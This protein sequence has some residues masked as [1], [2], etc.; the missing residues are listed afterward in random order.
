MSSARLVLLVPS[1]VISLLVIICPALVGNS[2][3][4]SVQESDI[5]NLTTTSN[6]SLSN[7]TDPTLNSTLNATQTDS[8]YGT[9]AG[10]LQEK[11]TG[12]IRSD[13]SP[14]VA[15]LLGLDDTYP[16]VMV[17]EV[18]PGSP[19]DEA[20]LR[21]ANMTRAVDGE[22][23]RLGG[24]IV[25]AVNGNA[26]VV[27]DDQ[28]FV[29]YLQNEKLVGDNI[30]LTVLRDGNVNEVELTLG[31]LPQFFWYVDDDEGIRIL[32]PS[33]W[34]VSDS[35]LGPSDVIRFFSPEE[36][37]ELGQSSAAVLIKVSPANGMT[38][39]EF[40]AQLME[41]TPGTRVLDI[42]G[43][44]LSGLQAYERVFYEYGANRTL[45]VKSVFTLNDDQLYRINYA[46]DIP[47]YDDY[48]PMVDEMLK[49]F[50]FTKAD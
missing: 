44:E 50:E 16:G 3:A 32:Y 9:G 24:D 22:I 33:D 15:E 28:A 42:R 37:A 6:S 49:S 25:V 7:V 18:T 8:L 46:A 1:S 39:D 13:I 30:T 43:T 26:S 11:Y 38:L 36:N 4:S 5:A 20:G 14:A 35:N 17:M 40:A 29:D 21:G 19:A 10:L 47:K 31:S 48:L 12:L 45:K 41:G 34:R 23:V 2:L 27:E